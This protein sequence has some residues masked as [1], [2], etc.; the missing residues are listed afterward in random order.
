[1][2][3]SIREALLGGPGPSCE[4]PLKETAWSA[5]T[6]LAPAPCHALDAAA[7]V[8]PPDGGYL[9][10]HLGPDHSG[11]AAQATLRRPRAP[12]HLAIAGGWCAPSSCANTSL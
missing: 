1:M 11:T 12:R 9:A 2:L 10:N 8:G 3:P 7:V 5:G 6:L 4:D